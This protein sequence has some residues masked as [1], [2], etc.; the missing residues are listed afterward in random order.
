[1]ILMAWRNSINVIFE[2]CDSLLTQCLPFLHYKL[3]ILFRQIQS[4]L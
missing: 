1:M 4:A 3:Y 2:S